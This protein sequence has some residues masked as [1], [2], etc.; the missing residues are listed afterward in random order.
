MKKKNLEIKVYDN[1]TLHKFHSVIDE[2]FF[3]RQDNYFTAFFDSP[4][5][6]FI[7]LS[8]NFSQVVLKNENLQ[9]S[10][11]SGKKLQ[12]REVMIKL[13]KEEVDDSSLAHLRID[14]MKEQL[15]QK[16]KRITAL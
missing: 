3:G 12:V 9:F 5:D 2:E 8:E 11:A 15:Q 7:Y 16:E 4:E 1:E 6:V 13:L 14:K 10:Y